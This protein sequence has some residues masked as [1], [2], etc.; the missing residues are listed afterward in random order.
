M[1]PRKQFP[2][3]TREVM[4]TLAWLKSTE[5]KVVDTEDTPGVSY[6]SSPETLEGSR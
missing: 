6:M 2:Q 1:D 4:R 5:K 3:P